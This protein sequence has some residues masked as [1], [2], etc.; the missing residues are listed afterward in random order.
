MIEPEV[1]QLED[2]IYEEDEED[3][4]QDYGYGAKTQR[5]PRRQTTNE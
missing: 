4:D 3:E 2:I 1:I 5:T